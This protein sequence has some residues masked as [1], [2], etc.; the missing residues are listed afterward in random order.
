MPLIKIIA[1]STEKSFYATQWKFQS[2]DDTSAD[3]MSVDETPARP[4]T[5][6]LLFV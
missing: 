5:F 4:I 1:S 2:I 6:I 3:E